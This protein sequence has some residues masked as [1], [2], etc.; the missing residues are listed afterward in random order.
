MIQNIK[1]HGKL[2]AGR[3]LARLWSGNLS[4]SQAETLNPWESSDPEYRSEMLSHLHLMADIDGLAGD[5]DILALVDTRPR[6]ERLTRARWYLAAAGVVL[7]VALGLWMLQMPIST[8]SADVAR[9]VTR[10]GEVKV[11]ELPDGSVISMN[12]GTEL[13]ATMTDEVRRVTL[14][15]GEAHF[16]V[17]A[18]QT[19]PF[20]VD[21]GLRSI[22]VLGTAFNLRRYPEQ[23]DVA[24]TEGMVVV[25]PTEQ[26]PSG[27]APLLEMARGAAAE[28]VRKQQPGQLRLAAGWKARID[29]VRQLIVG[30]EISG[31]VAS[32][33]SGQL[34]FNR[35]PLYQV[36][37]ELNRY[38]GKKI[39]IED[40]AV[41]DLKVS[42][43]FDIDRIDRA[44]QGLEGSL[45][46]EVTHFFDRI[47]IHGQEN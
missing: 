46:I 8:S 35:I 5:P 47:V 38:T 25:H 32:W 12:T 31:T 22:T 42:A 29:P 21:A 9:Y 24:V 40:S 1:D 4:G 28:E 36:V 14:K 34:E 23:L 44:L 11:V 2:R 13:L 45:P 7:A 26:A 27:Q 33:R 17:T 15:R 37:A 43:I 18:D 20:S 41:I 10:I 39:L 16:Q 3:S 6:R 19:R 30:R